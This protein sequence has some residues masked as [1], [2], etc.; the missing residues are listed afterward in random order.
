MSDT[1]AA[2]SQAQ[3]AP[4]R[5]ALFRFES[6]FDANRARRV[7]DHRKE[8]RDRMRR[9]FM[10]ARGIQPA[11]DAPTDA[12]PSP[13]AATESMSVD[14]APV[15]RPFAEVLA[16]Q[17]LQRRQLADETTRELQQIIARFSPAVPFDSP[18]LLADLARISAILRSTPAVRK[19]QADN[20]RLAQE[21]GNMLAR[22][23]V[24]T[25]ADRRVAER[26]LCIASQ[27]SEPSCDH[28]QHIAE[29]VCNTLVRT[30]Y[31]ADL[32]P[33]LVMCNDVIF[34]TAIDNPGLIPFGLPCV[35]MELCA[36]PDNEI[37]L[38]SFSA[39][40]AVV[41][42]CGR[43]TVGNPIV[44]H[45]ERCAPPRIEPFAATDNLFFYLQAMCNLLDELGECA[46]H[47]MHQHGRWNQ[48]ITLV[49]DRIHT[50]ST[51]IQRRFVIFMGCAVNSVVGAPVWLAAF[52]RA[53]QPH[54]LLSIALRG[55][56]HNTFDECAPLYTSFLHTHA[57][58]TRAAV[59]SAMHASGGVPTECTG[60]R[61]VD[62]YMQEQSQFDSVQ[63]NLRI[64]ALL[65][66]D[67]ESATV[68]QARSVISA[69]L[70]PCVETDVVAAFNE[71]RTLRADGNHPQ[72]CVPMPMHRQMPPKLIALAELVL[73]SLP[74]DYPATVTDPPTAAVSQ[75]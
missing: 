60:H 42:S 64:Q 23:S 57:S 51:S 74:I 22:T 62:E 16:M 70:G 3:P 11:L 9:E 1:V 73:F 19:A 6:T 18:H 29:W 17:E 34:V 36:S 71:Y 30:P 61:H 47:W 13:A 20:G 56:L 7:A 59:A 72:G 75:A 67:K 26:I 48:F 4:A 14:T 10:R 66:I 35:L 50:R 21:L 32:A 45:G 44:E 38:S 8:Q 43:A 53:D 46:I 65:C 63:K 55:A 37:A 12:P 49:G 54:S 25:P 41:L 39:L 68:D 58:L 27:L 69:I 2:A 24:Q 31:T 40:G 52:F 33:L 28:I 15:L 5:V